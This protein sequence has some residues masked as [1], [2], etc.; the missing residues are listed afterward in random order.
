MHASAQA[1][2]RISAFKAR[3]AEAEINAANGKKKQS[4]VDVA[5]QR[6]KARLRAKEFAKQRKNDVQDKKKKELEARLKKQCVRPSAL[7]V[8]VLTRSSLWHTRKMR[9]DRVE[10]RE[11][12]RAQIYA[13]NAIMLRWNQNQMQ[14][15]W[16]GGA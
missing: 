5:Q 16:L 14:A 12:R 6:E 11:Q 1:Q 4:S 8:R 15:C 13:I 3:A 9:Q 10:Q 2:E 7:L